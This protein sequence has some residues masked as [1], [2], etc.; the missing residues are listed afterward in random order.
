MD[1][2][3]ESLQDRLGYR[4]EAPAL[5]TQAL[6][7]RSH[8]RNHNERLE[9]LGDSV[10]NCAVAAMLY[11]RFSRYDEGDLSRL[12]SNLVKQQ[13]LYEIAQAL[14]IGEV[15]VLGEGER[16]Y[17]YDVLLHEVLQLGCGQHIFKRVVERL[18]IRVDLVLHISGKEPELL[19]G[20]NCWTRKYHLAHLPVFES[21]HGKGYRHIRLARSCWS[22]RKRQI[23]FLKCLDK[24]LLIG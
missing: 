11:A 15:L 4:F 5:L 9:F 12:R 3:L 20:L 7:H 8:G 16:R 23:V 6:T 14:A 10:L 2:S 21:T 13:S 22:E 17:L 19:A 18:E 1:S 24:F